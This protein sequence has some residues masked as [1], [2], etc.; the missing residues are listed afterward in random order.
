MRNNT[1]IRSI[2]G[3]YKEYED[4]IRNG[5]PFVG[6]EES[7]I[8]QTS[9]G[10]P[11]PHMRRVAGT[12]GGEATILFRYDFVQKNK[13]VFSAYCYNGRVVLVEDC[14]SAPIPT[15]KPVDPYGGSSD[16]GGSSS[17]HCDPKEFD[18]PDDFY[19]RYIDEFVDYEE[20]EEYHYSH[21]GR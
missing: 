12:A 17:L 5:V 13:T 2:I 9:L 3:S 20:A 4:K 15:N 14:R 16:S 18:S 6:L 19:Y 8:G 10:K 7:R 21:G 11:D 1:L